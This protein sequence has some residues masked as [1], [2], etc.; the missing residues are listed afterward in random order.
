[1]TEW[2]TSPSSVGSQCYGDEY[3][4]DTSEEF[5]RHASWCSFE[6]WLEIV[7]KSNNVTLIS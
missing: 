1:M 2:M 3:E 5:G 7:F 6:T 4:P